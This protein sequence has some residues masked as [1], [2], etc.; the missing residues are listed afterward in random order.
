MIYGL[1]NEELS[2]EDCKQLFDIITEK[3]SLLLNHFF[4]NQNVASICHETL[5]RNYI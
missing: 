3:S 2:Y 5:M 1:N 4:V